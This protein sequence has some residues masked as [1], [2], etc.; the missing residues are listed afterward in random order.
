M[1]VIISLIFDYKEFVDANRIG[2]G[3][4]RR[5]F[6]MLNLNRTQRSILGEG[7]RR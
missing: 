5:S 7:P 1:G 6:E 2:F 3:F 4:A